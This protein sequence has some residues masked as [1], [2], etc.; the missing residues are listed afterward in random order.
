MKV[1]QLRKQAK[2]SEAT[3]FPIIFLR[4]LCAATCIVCGPTW[5]KFELIQNTKHFLVISMFKKI[6]INSNR[7]GGD[8]DFETVN[9]SLLRS[10]L[11]LQA[12]MHVLVTSKNEGDPIENG[13]RV[14]T[15]FL[16]LSIYGDFSRRSRVLPSPWSGLAKV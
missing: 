3:I 6:R 10:Q 14:T 2:K 13:H 4:R 15:T 9:D 5:P 16:I 12:L 8:I 7:K 1:S 11:W